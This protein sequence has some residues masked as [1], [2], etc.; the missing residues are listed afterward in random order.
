MLKSRRVKDKCRDI[1]M[2]VER[3][4]DMFV[5]LPSFPRNFHLGKCYSCNCVALWAALVGLQTK[6]A[7]ASVVLLRVGCEPM[8]S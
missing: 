5:K 3:C 2:S 6:A 1:Q 4:G 8:T 7:A